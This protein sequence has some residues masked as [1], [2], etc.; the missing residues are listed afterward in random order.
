MTAAELANMRAGVSQIF[1]HLARRNQRLVGVLMRE[2]DGA[3]RGEHDPDRLATLFRLDQLATRMGRYNDNLL[4]VGGQTASRVDAADVP[5]RHGAPGRPVEDRALPTDRA[6]SS[7]TRHLVVRGSA[8]HDLIN[9]LA[10]LLDN[11]TAFSPPRVARHGHRGRRAGDGSSS[12]SGTPGVGIPPWRIEAINEALAAP[13]AIDISA[14][15][16]DGA[17]R[18]RPH[19]RP[20]R[21]IGAR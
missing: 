11:A 21:D 3:E 4:V 6:S 20:A 12:A 8:V 17:D 13:P 7:P 15:P 18:G 16:V 19:R 5:L 2:L 1:L 9:L 10:E 14:D